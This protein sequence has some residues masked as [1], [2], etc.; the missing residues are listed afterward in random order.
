M[1]ARRILSH[2]SVVAVVLGLT[3]PVAAQEI[4]QTHLEAALEVLKSSPASRSYDD[5]L[6]AVA[7]AVKS[8]L[9]LQRPDLHKQI[10]E[11]VDTLVVTLVPRRSDLDNDLARVW[12]KGFTEDELVTIASFYSSPAGQKFSQ[13]GPNV[14]SE[15]YKVAEGWAVRVREELLEKSRLELQKEGVEF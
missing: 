13:I 15:G 9:I 11:T 6:P 7:D 1:F 14:I 10:S 3:G 2:A 8:Q 5:L 4:T 12:A